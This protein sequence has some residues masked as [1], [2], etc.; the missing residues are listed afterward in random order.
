[1][2]FAN[3]KKLMLCEHET[4]SESRKWQEEEEVEG[5]AATRDSRVRSR[6]HWKTPSKTCTTEVL[7]TFNSSFRIEIYK[8]EKYF[9]DQK[10]HVCEQESRKLGNILIQDIHGNKLENQFWVIKNKMENSSAI[11]GGRELTAARSAFAF[12]CI[13]SRSLRSIENIHR[14]VPN[15]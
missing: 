14:C 13:S 10:T 9:P 12:R 7:L 6:S 2:E 1:M 15:T 5:A 8:L 11:F 4:A 3:G